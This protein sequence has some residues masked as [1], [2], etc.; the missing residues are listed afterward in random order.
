MDDNTEDNVQSILYLEKAKK[1]KL[2]T[3]EAVET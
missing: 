1:Q 3:T 2:R